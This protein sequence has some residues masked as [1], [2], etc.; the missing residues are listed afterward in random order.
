MAEDLDRESLDDLERAAD[1]LRATLA[2]LQSQSRGFATD[3]TGGLKSAVLEAKRLD[4]AF[5]D[6]ALSM[7]GRLLDSALKPLEDSLTKLFEVLFSG[8]TGASS[9]SLGSGLGGSLLGSLVPSISGLF[10]FAK[11]GV[12]SSPV[13][14]PF[15]Q[16]AIGM[17]GEAGAEAILPLARGAD[18]RLGV[19]G[20]GSGAVNVTFNVTASDAESFRRSETQVTTM[21][22]RAVGRGRRGL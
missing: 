1:T 17:A 19:R 22:A 9:G 14:F 10:G 6:I 4:T 13:A 8:L 2:D 21:L 18:G 5:K 15:G 16:N 7:S 11:G 3:I 12:V 20:P